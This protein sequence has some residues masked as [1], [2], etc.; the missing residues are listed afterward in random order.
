MH[1]GLR[2]L[3]LA[4][5][6]RK[7]PALSLLPALERYDGPWFRVLRKFLHESPSEASRL[8]VY[9]LS[10][11]F[12]LIPANQLIPDYD[13]RISRQQACK[14]NPVVL[15]QLQRLLESRQYTEILI[16]VGKD[17][18]QALSGYEHLLPPKVKVVVSAGGLGRK[19]TALHD[20]L[21]NRYDA[22]AVC[23]K[24]TIIHHGL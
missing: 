21:R 10:A 18:L 6:Q 2:L 14:L 8:Q 20:W 3:I 15:D 4:C 22:E 23:I 16:S 11:E 17:Y 7:R 24:P 13:R 9:I 12:G 19:Q 1:N 5:S